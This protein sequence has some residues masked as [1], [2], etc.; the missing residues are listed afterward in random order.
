MLFTLVVAGITGLGVC[1][2]VI[3]K[4]EIAI[5]KIRIGTYWIVSLAGAV[6]LLAFGAVSPADV[7]CKFT[8]NTAVNPLKIL[9]L[10]F[11][12]TF[13]SV[14]LD[15]IGVLSILRTKWSKNAATVR[16]LYL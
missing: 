7:A 9:L 14:F 12:M 10:F 4:P 13:L 16:S 11:T 15:E 1:A 6:V 5:G 8:E 3:F 2:S